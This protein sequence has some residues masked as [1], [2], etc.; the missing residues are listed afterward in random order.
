MT[1]WNGW[2][3]VNGNTYGTWLPGDKRGWRSRHHK[4]HVDGDYRY[5]P[6]PGT[7]DA[8]HDHTQSNLSQPPV[9]LDR[10]Q[11]QIVGESLVEMFRRQ[12]VELLALSM[13]AIHFHLLARFGNRPARTVVGRAKK[14]ATFI[15]KKLGHEGRVWTKRARVL[16]ITD[17]D[18]QINV[19]NYI[20]GHQSKG[21]WT[22]RF[23]DTG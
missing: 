11:R 21:A 3:H 17:R 14:H 9:H 4:V 16:P 2:Y 6:P 10:R 15:L 18:H 1:A 20:R 8:L 23:Q 22:W 7:Y 13:D 12:E 19:F 5:P